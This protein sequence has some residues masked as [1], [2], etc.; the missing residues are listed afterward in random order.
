MSEKQEESQQGRVVFSD[1]ALGR[2]AFVAAV[3]CLAVSALL[4]ADYIIQKRENFIDSEQLAALKEQLKTDPGNER[5]REEIRK[6]D[7][8]LRRAYFTRVRRARWA[9]YLL[10][11]GGVLLVIALRVR[12]ERNPAPYLPGP[13]QPEAEARLSLHSRI[14][15]A[16]FSLILIGLAAYSAGSATWAL[17]PEALTKALK[18]EPPYAPPEEVA[19]Q[20]PRFRGP[21]GSG[22][23]PYE[24]IP[25]KWDAKTGLNIL[26]KVPVP[27]PGNSSPIVWKDRVFLTGATKKERAVFCFST[28]NG[29]LLWRGSMAGIPGSPTKAPEVMDDTG[30]ASPTP[31]TDGRR[32]YA[33]FA[34]GDLA[35]FNFEG[36]RLWAKNLGLPDNPYGHAASLLCWRNVLIVPFDQGDEDSGKARLYAFDGRTGR[37]VWEVKRPVGSSWSTPIII[38]NINGRDLVVTAATPW[39]IAYDVQTG[40]EIWRADCLDGDVAPSPI[41]AGGFVFAVNTGAVLAAIRPDGT[42]NVTDTH[43]AWRAEDGLP[44]ICSPAA[45]GPWVFLCETE[46]Y[47]VCYRIKDGRLLWEHEFDMTFMSSP[48]VVGNLLYLVN[49]KGKCLVCRPNEKG[50]KVEETSELGEPVHASPAFADGKIY[51]RTRKHLFCIGR[52]G[53]ARDQT[54]RKPGAPQS[55]KEKSGKVKEK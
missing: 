43:I 32:V 23:S 40:K 18:E 3:F 12:R 31:A 36:R 27:L 20:W 17:P 37:T 39:V 4:T 34:N 2:L 5:L 42:G 48:S 14:A 38:S 15:V 8:S 44:D 22:H 10:V 33:V 9:A 13:K 30:Y 41:F 45:L 19:L 1:T 47:F 35:A 21:G 55:G 49:V 28:E 25:K 50:L 26:W 7:L 6:K 16:A 24:N 54:V 46:G 52:K 29:T 51:I 53:P 11:G